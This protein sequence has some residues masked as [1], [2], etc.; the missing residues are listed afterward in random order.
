MS[1]A[2]SPF[3]VPPSSPANAGRRARIVLALVALGIAA[4]LL[5]YAISPSVRHAVTHAAHSVG[6]VLDRDAKKRATT[7]TGTA[8]A[9][10]PQTHSGQSTVKAPTPPG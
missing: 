9:P 6:H 8:P 1:M 10:A 5:A 3:S 7:P 4:S 2:M